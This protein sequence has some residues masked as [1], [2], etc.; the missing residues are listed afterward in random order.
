MKIRYQEK[1]C[2]HCSKVFDARTYQRYCSEKCYNRARYERVLIGD[3]LIAK[4]EC[5]VCKKEFQPIRFNVKRCSEVCRNIYSKNWNEERSKKLKE[6][7]LKNTIPINCKVC[8]KEFKPYPI[9]RKNCSPKCTKDY[10]RN[11]Q[12]IYLAKK[13]LF[14]DKLNENVSS[15][16]G[17]QFFGI[18]GRQYTEIPIKP[19]IKVSNFNWPPDR[20]EITKAMEE[21]VGGGG[22]IRK[23]DVQVAIDLINNNPFVDP[24]QDLELVIDEYKK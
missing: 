2:E 10:K 15:D 24:L 9:K 4:K 20:N 21:F 18:K 11:T 19:A 17:S 22:E 13:K 1:E 3:T 12:E 23:L 16:S 14:S 6:K 8:G 5:D 7:I